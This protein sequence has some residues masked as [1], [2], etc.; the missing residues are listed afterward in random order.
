MSKYFGKISWWF[1]VVLIGIIFGLGVGLIRA[2]T[3]PDQAPPA[4]NLPAPINIGSFGQ[5]KQGGLILNTGGAPNG[6]IV[7]KGNVG[8]G[9]P[10]PGQKLDV[11]GQIHATGDI[12]TDAGGGICLSQLAG[13]LPRATI[14]IKVSN[15]DG[16]GGPYLSGD[17]ACTK[18]GYSDCKIVLRAEVAEHSDGW[19]TYNVPCDYV[20]G[21]GRHARPILEVECYE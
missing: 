21:D 15:P 1:S 4:G 14:I 16:A 20:F 18:K 11:T 10:D 9:T 17:I 2:W 3:E 6:L 19:D 8:I 13:L 12:C 7:D 5:A